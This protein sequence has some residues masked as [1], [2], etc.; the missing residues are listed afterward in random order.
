MLLNLVRLKYRDPSYFL[1]VG[2]V[3]AS[4][5]FG[6]NIGVGT[7][8]DVG[9]GVSSVSP[10][11]GVSYTDRPTITY[12]PLQGEDFLKSIMSSISL[13]AVLVMA[14]S[15]WGIERVIGITM[16]RMNDLYNAPGASGPTPDYAPDFKKFK[17]M[18][19]LLRELQAKGDIEIGT[20][21][22][23]RTKKK[24]R[25]IIFEPSN[26]NRHVIKELNSLLGFN[27]ADESVRLSLT[28]NFLNPQPNQLKVRTR[29]I[30]SVLYYLSQNVSIPEEHK[31]EGL[32]TITH[33]LSGEEFN[34]GET[35]AGE[36]FKV[37][38][39]EDYPEHAFIAVPYR[40]YWFYLADDDLQ[41]KATFMLLMQLFDLQAG[42]TKYT[43]P[44]LTLPV[45]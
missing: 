36:V 15:G 41:T 44:T 22:N 14:Q 38:F 18:L 45:Q 29:S 1:K 12:S 27:G 24:N 43:G 25:M 9:S 28:T 40:G 13:E 37:K 32:V 4:L 5:T 20:D 6:S 19:A 21:M 26:L 35:P 7:K 42:Q 3:T 8:L 23:L 34:W 10:S 17:R 31:N 16:E 33:T 39:S 30:S 2:S 11:L